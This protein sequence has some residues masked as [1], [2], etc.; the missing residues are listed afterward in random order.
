MTLPAL[1]AL[2]A[3]NHGLITLDQS[4]SVGGVQEAIES[5]EQRGLVRLVYNN[6][7]S[8]GGSSHTWHQRALGATWCTGAGALLSHRSASAIWGLQEC[9]G[10]E[11]LVPMNTGARPPGIRVHQTR[12]L[13]GVDVDQR[14]GIR[15]TSIE[16]TLVDM[17]AITPLGQLAR[18]VDASV[19]AGLDLL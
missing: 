11:V 14:Q 5:M 17:A 3:A 12:F 13:T 19:A 6:V 15:V 7:W 16:R 9:R 2:P 18:L 4:K 1:L 8:A 10:V